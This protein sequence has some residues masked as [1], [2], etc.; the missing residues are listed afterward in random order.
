MVK[1]MPSRQAEVLRRIDIEEEVATVARSLGI[2]RGNLAVRLHRARIDLRQRLAEA[3]G[4]TSTSTCR[5]CSTGA[6]TP[7]CS[8]S[9]W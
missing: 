1:A 6:K 5:S 7:R 9:S 2:T 8:A 4:T 3:C